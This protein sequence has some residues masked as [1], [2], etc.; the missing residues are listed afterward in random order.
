M[1]VDNVTIV[2][3]LIIASSPLFYINLINH[4]TLD[5]VFLTLIAVARVFPDKAANL[6]GR[7]IGIAR[8]LF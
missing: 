3:F 4:N 7:F 1:N 2:S 8:F 6:E 5:L